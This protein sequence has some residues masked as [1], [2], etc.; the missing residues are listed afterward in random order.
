MLRPPLTCLE[1]RPSIF[2]KD[3]CD[4]QPPRLEAVQIFKDV[5]R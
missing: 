3:V 1:S 4:D 2:D 5:M